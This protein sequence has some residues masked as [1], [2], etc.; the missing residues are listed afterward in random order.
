MTDENP[1]TSTSE[2]AA[3]SAN[4]RVPARAEGA[5]VSAVSALSPA[6]RPRDEM[7]SIQQRVTASA[8]Y[9][10]D[11]RYSA[12]ENGIYLP[13][14]ARVGYLIMTSGVEELN[15]TKRL[16]EVNCCLCY[17]QSGLVETLF[18]QRLADGIDKSTLAQLEPLLHP[19][20]LFGRFHASRAEVLVLQARLAFAVVQP[21]W[22]ATI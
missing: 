17:G 6:S 12:G 10:D 2:V 22:R 19:K 11:Q 9:L 1:N 15:K 16:L 3:A 7:A 13:R 5:S 20:L 14:K 8:R 21:A 4:S 18:A